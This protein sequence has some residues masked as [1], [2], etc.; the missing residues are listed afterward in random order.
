MT[1]VCKQQRMVLAYPQHRFTPE[2]LLH[3]IEST[4]FTADWTTLGLDDEDDL[5]SLQMCIMARPH[6]DT[7]IDG[8]GGLSLHR[9]RF[10]W[11]KTSKEITAYYWY[12]EEFGIVYLLCVD[13]SAERLNFTDDQRM[14]IRHEFERVKGGLER[15]GAIR[16]SNDNQ[17]LVEPKK[18]V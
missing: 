15:K 14:G 12:F 3:F 18:D 9:H 5:S 13:D 11:H 4:Q 17:P 16:L 7:K 2:D 1:S 8:T 10:W 6:G